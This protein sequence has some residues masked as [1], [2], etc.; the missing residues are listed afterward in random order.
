MKKVEV[1][2]ELQLKS[3]ADKILSPWFRSALFSK[4]NF[5]KKQEEASTKWFT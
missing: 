2:T 5:G 1:R 4:V 3:D